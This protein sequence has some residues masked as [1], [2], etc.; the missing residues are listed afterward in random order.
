MEIYEMKTHKH[1]CKQ[2]MV[3]FA[4]HMKYKNNMVKG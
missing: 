2:F 1:A 3:K 4:V